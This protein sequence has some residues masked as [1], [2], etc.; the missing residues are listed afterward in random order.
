[1]SA[2]HATLARTVATH[3]TELQALRDH[4]DAA[5]RA[6]EDAVR[7]AVKELRTEWFAK[8]GAL[9]GRIEGLEREVAT[10]RGEA[11]VLSQQNK[12]AARYEPRATEGV[13]L[14]GRPMSPST[15]PTPR[16]LATLPSLFPPPFAPRNAPRAR[17]R[18]AELTDHVRELAVEVSG[19]P[20]PE[21]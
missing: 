16:S 15:L 19:A 12:D 1:M 2:S 11:N 21:E 10:Q 14:L 6:A 7:A 17:R 5:A 18:I 4:R 3:A 9:V 20:L 8:L 13:A